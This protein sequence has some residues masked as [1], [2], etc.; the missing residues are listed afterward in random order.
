MGRGVTFRNGRDLV[1]FKPSYL[2][3]YKLYP[4]L[5]PRGTEVSD[6]NPC[7]DWE[8]SKVGREGGWER[9]GGLRSVCPLKSR[10]L[11]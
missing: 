4:P 11:S 3:T 7:N 5:H 2:V 10:V 6:P 8:G 9:E 1:G